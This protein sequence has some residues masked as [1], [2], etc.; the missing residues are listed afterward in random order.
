MAADTVG[1]IVRLEK[2]RQPDIG[3]PGESP[4]ANSRLILT[5]KGI[6]P[7]LLPI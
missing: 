3:A 5:N 4:R 7:L 2:G 6:I 1:K